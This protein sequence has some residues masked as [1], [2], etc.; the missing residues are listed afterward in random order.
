MTCTCHERVNRSQLYTEA[1]SVG[2][3]LVPVFYVVS[4][5]TS[6]LR[7]DAFTGAFKP[8]LD[9]FISGALFH[10]IAEESGLNEWY[11]T[12]SH[13]AQKIMDT[14]VNDGSVHGSMDW[15]RA[16]ESLHRC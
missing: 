1:V 9:L 8:T 3:A 12:N 6:A 14:V 13:A 15:L 7:V 11:L 4:R 10:L 2:F 5:A 16:V